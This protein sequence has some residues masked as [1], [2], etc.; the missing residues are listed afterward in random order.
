MRLG[1]H[2]TSG[3]AFAIC[4]VDSRGPAAAQKCN[5]LRGR[6]WL[7]DGAS[8]GKSRVALQHPDLEPVEAAAFDPEGRRIAT[9]HLYGDLLVWDVQT[10][11]LITRLAGHQRAV[12]FLAF[13]RTGEKLYSAGLDGT[14][15]VWSV[16]AQ[17]QLHVLEHGSPIFAAGLSAKADYMA[18]GA[19]DGSVV[20]WR[21]TDGVIIARMRHD[22]AVFAVAFT[23]DGSGLVTVSADKSARVWDVNTGQLRGEPLLLE[24]AG[25][26]V[27]LS[28]GVAL[29]TTTDRTCRAW[30]LKTGAPL[31][32]S[33]RHA[34]RVLSSVFSHDGELLLTGSLDQTARLWCVATGRPVGPALTHP[35][36]VCQTVWDWRNGSVLTA[37]GGVVR[38]WNLFDRAVPADSRVPAWVKSVTGCSLTANGELSELSRDEW[39]DSTQPVK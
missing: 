18:T 34:G 12:K 15:R 35:D 21:T 27:A 22:A 7:W 30:D 26:G 2:P 5:D 20:L 14:A 8:S 33:P 16:A 29:A 23:P 28:G 38:R 37:A 9:S 6:L 32:L 25:F 13:D 1:L 39:H 19:L 17:T 31:T 36:S 11:E 10:R 3:S 4:Q 24:N